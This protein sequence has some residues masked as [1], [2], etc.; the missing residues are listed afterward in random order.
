MELYGCFIPAPLLFPLACLGLGAQCS[1]YRDLLYPAQYKAL[2]GGEEGVEGWAGLS[3]ELLATVFLRLTV[4]TPG[5]L[6]RWPGS[7]QLRFVC[8]SWR[9]VHD[10]RCVLFIKPAAFRPEL[11]AARF[12]ALRSLDLSRCKY[13]DEIGMRELLASLRQLESLTLKDTGVGPRLAATL[14]EGLVATGATPVQAASL[15][16]LTLPAA[17]P[18]SR[19]LARAQPLQQW[20]G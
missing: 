13:P 9:R 5:L 6:L 3:D 10:S 18:R 15:P 4:A 20:C 16:T 7:C 17:C 8:R 12:P 19:P 1:V 11:T 2:E 14:A